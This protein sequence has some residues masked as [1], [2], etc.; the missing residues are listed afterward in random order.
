MKITS[1]NQ[2]RTDTPSRKFTEE[3][4]QKDFEYEVAQMLTK[5]LMDNGLISEDETVQ[6][7]ELNK[8][9]FEPFYKEIL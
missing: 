5:K 4:M 7:S 1:N 8:L 3:K 6:I 9:N 2:I